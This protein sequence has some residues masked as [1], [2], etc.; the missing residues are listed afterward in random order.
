MFRKIKALFSKAAP[1]PAHV[2]EPTPA[3]LR[4]WG[5]EHGYSVGDRGRIPSTVHAAFSVAQKR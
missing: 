4:A 2:A 1:A 3:E 5:R